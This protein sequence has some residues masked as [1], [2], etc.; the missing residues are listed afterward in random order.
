MA[1]R[2]NSLDKALAVALREAAR[3]ITGIDREKLD[4]QGTR[5]G[6][7]VG[8]MAAIQQQLAVP[9]IIVFDDVQV[10]WCWSV[11]EP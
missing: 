7:F 4:E 10:R 8:M 2:C 5:N 6:G 1:Q 11:I 3:Y 9:L